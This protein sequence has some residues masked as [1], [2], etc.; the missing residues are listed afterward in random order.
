MTPLLQ[1]S[2]ITKVFPGVRALENVQLELWPG[3]VTALIGENGAG[4]ST[5]I[6]MMC[7]ILTPTSG[8]LPV[9]G[10]VLFCCGI[11]VSALMVVLPV[12]MFSRGLRRYESGNG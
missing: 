6:K 12:W 5:T 7:G 2:D 3:K 4:K 10:L 8:E 1:L 9:N 11:L